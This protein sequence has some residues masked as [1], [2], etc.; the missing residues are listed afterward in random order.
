M[1]I[2]DAIFLPCQEAGLLSNKSFGLSAIGN[3]GNV[4][5]IVPRRTK[6]RTDLRARDQSFPFCQARL[7][8]KPV[9][10]GQVKNFL[11]IGDVFPLSISEYILRPNSFEDDL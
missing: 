4:G 3:W 8:P 7:D 5:D 9:C 1:S 10:P 11:G 6:Q 2:G